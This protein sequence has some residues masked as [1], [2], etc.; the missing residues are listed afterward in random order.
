MPRR[1]SVQCPVCGAPLQMDARAASALCAHCHT[2]SRVERVT[3]A[4][5]AAAAGGEPVIRVVVRTGF[6]FV[7]IG[8]GVA[9]AGALL[10]VGGLLASSLVSSPSDEMAKQAE[11][12]VDL[13]AQARRLDSYHA[14]ARLAGGTIV[15]GSL[16][17]RLVYLD[18]LGQPRAQIELPLPKREA[19]LGGLAS[20]GARGLFASFGGAIYRV[21]GQGE[22][23]GPALPSETDARVYGAIA[24]DA[25]GALY[26]LTASGELAL[27]GADARPVQSWQLRLPPEVHP[28]SVRG[29]AVAPDGRVAIS[30]PHGKRIWVFDTK[31]VTLESI[32]VRWSSALESSLAFC[33]DGRLAFDVDR[34]LHLLSLGTGDVVRPELARPGWLTFH[35]LASDPSGGLVALSGTG[36]LVYWGGARLAAKRR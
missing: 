36:T 9:V 6:R 15:V 24:S 1:V 33:A 29:L 27:L 4:A 12:V 20:A 23:V 13:S 35:A 19:Q 16:A 28:P 30:E 7:G 2:R 21:E 10:V 5:G 14:V 34:R 32:Q 18:A 26:A 11:L 31:L 8:I 25:S 17:G 3:S 22:R